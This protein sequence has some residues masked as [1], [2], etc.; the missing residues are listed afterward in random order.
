MALTFHAL[1]RG[2]MVL[3]KLALFDNYL[4]LLLCSM[5]VNDV[6]AQR[7]GTANT[8]MLDMS[9]PAIVW[10]FIAICFNG[11]EMIVISV[12]ILY[13]LVLFISAIIEGKTPYFW[14]SMSP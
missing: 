4:P 12:S 14:W 2:D 6:N 13:P 11:V 8:S 10:K 9:P 1:W 3:V 7:I 5:N